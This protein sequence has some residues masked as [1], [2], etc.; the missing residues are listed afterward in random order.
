MSE[1]TLDEVLDVPFTFTRRPRALPCDMRPVWRL[2]VLVLILDQCR[3]GKASLEQL[4]VFNWAMR[5]DETRN[6]FLQFMRGNRS[7]SQIIVRYDPS[8]SRAIEFA[9]AERLVV[10]NVVQKEL[11]E[12]E[13]ARKSAPPYR[14]ALSSTGRALV[15]AI[16]STA[17][18][19]VT[20][21]KFLEEIG[22][23]VSQSQIESLFTWSRR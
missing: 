23:K 20:E 1:A 22:S 4:H 3:G 16:K 5:T 10:R 8:L 18:A 17:D 12:P 19:F 15:E 21:K 7:P 6:L 11:F 14:V 2:H 9:F 13:A